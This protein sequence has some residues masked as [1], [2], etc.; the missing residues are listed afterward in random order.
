[1]NKKLIRLTEQ[2]LHRIVKESVEKILAE[3]IEDEGLGKWIRAG[4]DAASKKQ[5]T[6]PQLQP[7]K[8]GKFGDSIGNWWSRTKRNAQYEDDINYLNDRTNSQ[9]NSIHSKDLGGEGDE[10]YQRA[11]QRTKQHRAALS[12]K[13]GQYGTVRDDNGQVRNFNY[14][15]GQNYNYR[16]NGQWERSEDERF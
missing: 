3:N 1:M 16:G 6:N 5:R 4:I 14:N 15:N 7:Y 9:N 13:G 8:G 10:N 12:G 2:D 11:L